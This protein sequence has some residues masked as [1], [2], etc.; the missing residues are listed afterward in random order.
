[1]A[2]TEN[3]KVKILAIPPLCRSEQFRQF[4]RT[5]PIVN[6]VRSQLTTGINERI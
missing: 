2:S 3:T 5:F 4:Y 6:A 1:M